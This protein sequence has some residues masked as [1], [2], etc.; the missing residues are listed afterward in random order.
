MAEES[1]YKAVA[2]NGWVTARETSGC[3]ILLFT[4]V[5]CD[6]GRAYISGIRNI[7]FTQGNM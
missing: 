6:R 7:P 2:L 1:K 4:P 5:R 3:Q